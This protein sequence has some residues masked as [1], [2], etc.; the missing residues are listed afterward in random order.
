MLARVSNIEALRRWRLNEEP[1]EDLVRWITTDNPTPAMLAGTA[2]HKALELAEPGD[3]DRLQANGM[4][5]IMPDAE[6]ALTEIREMRAERQYGPLT[7]SGQ[8]D[9]LIGR[10]V[11]DHKTTIRFDA[12]RYLEGCQWKYY[13][14]IF[15][16]DEF[17][18]NVFE[19]KEVEPNVYRVSS[20]HILKAYRYPGMEEECHRLAL[21]YYDFAKAHLPEGGQDHAFKP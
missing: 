21:D 15:G 19:I 3:F 8:V 9:G 1:V 2:F 6:I 20:P 5:F 14:S 17:A 11:I 13:C 7:V 10:K 18:W 4:T 12:E 16:A